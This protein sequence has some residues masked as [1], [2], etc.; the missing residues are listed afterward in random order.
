MLS[1][2]LGR[3]QDDEKL[4]SQL[5]GLFHST[6]HK[7]FVNTSGSGKT[8]MVLEHLCT[9]WGL[10]F[11]CLEDS[12]I[13]SQDVACAIK[14]I[15]NNTSFSLF[16]PSAPS[17]E[18]SARD[19]RD[20][21]REQVLLKRI[22]DFQATA[23]AESFRLALQRNELIADCELLVVFLAR[24]QV[25]QRFSATLQRMRDDTER[26]V[27]KRNW[28][29][30][31]LHPDLLFSQDESGNDIFIQ[32]SDLI[33]AVLSQEGLDRS[34]DWKKEVLQNLSR[35]IISDIKA[36]LGISLAS[37][38]DPK[39]LFLAFDECQYA[40]KEMP[41]V[42]R[43][44][45]WTEIRPFLRYLAI[46]FTAVFRGSELPQCSFIFTGTGL[47]R[48][49]I[50]EALSLIVVKHGMVNDITQTGSFDEK[51][52][53]FEYLKK[54]FPF[55]DQEWKRSDLKCLTDRIFFWL[56]GWHRFTAEFIS[57]VLQNAYSN[58]NELLN[59]YIE[60]VAEFEPGDYHAI[61]RIPPTIRFPPPA[62]SF[63]RLSDMMKEKIKDICYSYLLTSKSDSFLGTDESEY[64]EC[65][66]ARFQFS[67]GKTI[68]AIDEPLVLPAC[69]VWFDKRPAHT[70]YKY[71]A[72]RIQVRSYILIF[73]FNV[74][75]TFFIL[76]ETFVAHRS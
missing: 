55:T 9:R 74:V 4:K 15:A 10:Y 41:F 45:T 33:N 30:L 22:R 66:F 12:R 51:A 72:D 70:L 11:T 48:N 69:A 14:R 60:S 13:G 49:I 63:D 54:F 36:T 31:Q 58:L 18:V 25:L 21:T 20:E 44:Q 37:Q 3:F 46:G 28:L 59:A 57:V 68:L 39:T 29:H 43:S 71:V 24:L 73:L 16:L 75:H 17:L 56:R 52:A 32:L 40:A 61:K 76:Q 23:E 2:Q 8:R 35:R 19:M 53:Q 50:D 5:E 7:L 27:R 62:F 34:L 6:N 38:E 42:F 65:G 26:L 1:Y 64:M 67:E 47:S